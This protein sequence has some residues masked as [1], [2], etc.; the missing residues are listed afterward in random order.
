[1]GKLFPN[2]ATGTC[3]V[4]PKIIHGITT[5]SGD[6]SAR[7]CGTPRRKDGSV[8][9]APRAS[10]TRWHMPRRRR[11]RRRTFCRGAATRDSSKRRTPGRSWRSRGRLSGT[12]PFPA[13]R[14]TG[15]HTSRTWRNNR[16]NSRCSL[17]PPPTSRSSGNVRLPWSSQSWFSVLPANNLG[18][19]RQA[20]GVPGGR[21]ARPR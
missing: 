1:M 19:S 8:R 18:C 20:G 15:R 9:D 4:A 10:R 17:A 11:H 5:P 12:P 16:D 2:K 13:R 21:K 3:Q 6:R 14:C 7:T